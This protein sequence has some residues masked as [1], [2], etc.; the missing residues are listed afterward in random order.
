MK[1]IK[2]SFLFTIITFTLLFVVIIPATAQITTASDFFKSVSEYYGTIT[3]YEANIEIIASS[4]TKEG[5]VSFKRPNLLRMDFTKPNGEV[6]VFNGDT[7]T[8]Y[9]P[10]IPVTLSQSLSNSSDSAGMN[11]STPQ[12]LALMSRY[13][14]VGY[15]IGQKPVPLDEN[16]EEKVIKLVLWPKNASEGFK[17]IKIAVSPDTK[18]IRKVEG[19]TQQN[20]TFILYFSNYKIN[21]NITDQR[22]VY[23]AP[24]TTNS[25][26]NFLLSE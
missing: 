6:Y 15:E 10:E 8:V 17:Q 13:Y 3:D 1:K 14:S 16:S 22:F 24:S 19:L 18:L 25:I 11:L 26:N 4:K 5:V 9:I 7:I 21:Q 12:G 20:Q 23:D 2:Q